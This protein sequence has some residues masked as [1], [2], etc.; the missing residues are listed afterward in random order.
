[1]EAPP[2]GR[3]LV[4]MQIW[5]QPVTVLALDAELA[6]S[7]EQL[8]DALGA[9]VGEWPPEGG[10]WDRAAVEFFR[11]RVDDGSAQVWGPAYVILNNRLVGNAG[12]LGPP[13]EEGEVEIGY[14]VCRVERRRGVATAAV[15][16]LCDLA[17]ARGWTSIRARTTAD[18]L[19]S[20]AVLERNWFT[21]SARATHDDGVIDLVL[22]RSLR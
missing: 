21:E 12:F 8:A 7:R 14:S 17:L 1:M 15:A 3:T 4:G 18:N 6:G 2:A 10:Q 5:L 9:E 11:Q 16:E 20:I 13:D 22:R 19:G